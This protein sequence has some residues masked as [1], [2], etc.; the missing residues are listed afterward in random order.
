MAASG[1]AGDLDFT[2]TL[3]SPPPSEA[4]TYR[5]PGNDYY[6]DVTYGANVG[7][8]YPIRSIHVSMHLPDYT[9]YSAKRASVGVSRSTGVLRLSTTCL[10]KHGRQEEFVQSIGEPI[11]LRV[12]GIYSYKPL[13]F[14][15]RSYSIQSPHKHVTYYNLVFN[16]VYNDIDSKTCSEESSAAAGGASAAPSVAAAAAGAAGAGGAGGGGASSASSAGAAPV[17]APFTAK[18]IETANASIMEDGTKFFA[19]MRSS[20]VSSYIQVKV[21]GPGI[22]ASS[23]NVPIYKI[24]VSDF[25]ITKLHDF[26]PDATPACLAFLEAIVSPFRPPA[27]DASRRSAR[28]RRSSRRTNRRKGTQRR[29]SKK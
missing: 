13:D 25:T 27:K 2:F 17:T 10:N 12:F 8:G 7:I 26:Y 24:N 18:L 9:E 22:R 16:D 19:E 20:V 3:D 11:T 29:S 28:K 23:T 4:I 5:F 6:L 21:L 15:C 14:R 1:V